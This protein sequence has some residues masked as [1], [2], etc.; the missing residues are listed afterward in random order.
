MLDARP[1]GTAEAS[2]YEHLLVIWFE[3][4]GVCDLLGLPAA[5]RTFDFWQSD[6]YKSL[7]RLVRANMSTVG[8]IVTAHAL[9][10]AGLPLRCG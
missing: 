7:Y 2:S 6:H 9:V 5:N 8:A 10:P 4:Q 3:Y 1:D